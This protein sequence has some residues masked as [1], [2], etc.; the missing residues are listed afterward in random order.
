VKAISNAGPLIALGK[1][2]QL[3]LLLKLFDEIIIP[4]EVYNEVVVNGLALGATEAGSIEFLIRQGHIQVRTLAL[5]FP[6]PQWA[7]SIDMGEVEVI[8]LALE[9]SA[10]WVLIDNSHARKAARQQGLQL[11]GTIG[12]LLKAFEEGLLSFR[13]FEL[14]IHDIEARPNLWISDSIC[15]QALARARNLAES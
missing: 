4:R 3:G 15:D 11:K 5:P 1:L 14:L 2:G 8:L 12:L 10:D 7:Q 6:L 9:E 13:E